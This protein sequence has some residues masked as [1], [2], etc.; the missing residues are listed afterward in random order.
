MTPTAKYQLITQRI[1][2]RTCRSN[3]HQELRL[4][5]LMVTSIINHTEKRLNG[6]NGI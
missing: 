1:S 5:S 6:K 4:E 3:D 2:S